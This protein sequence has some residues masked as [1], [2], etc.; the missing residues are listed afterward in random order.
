MYQSVPSTFGISVINGASRW[1]AA[2]AV[3]TG[4]AHKNAPAAAA[5]TAAAPIRAPARLFRRL[6]TILPGG[7]CIAMD[8]VYPLFELSATRLLLLHCTISETS[9]NG[10]ILS[11]QYCSFLTEKRCQCPQRQCSNWCQHGRLL[12]NKASIKGG[13]WSQ[14]WYLCWPASALGGMS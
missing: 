10:N 4:K 5:Q 11:V 7:L 13:V 1:L 14:I 12:V 6:M 9:Q 2:T 3:V 8:P